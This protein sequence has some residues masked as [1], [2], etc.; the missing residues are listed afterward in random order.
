MKLSAEDD[1]A[2]QT[3]AASK[4]SLVKFRRGNH[5]DFSFGLGSNMAHL[6]RVQPCPFPFHS[7]FTCW[8]DGGA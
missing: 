2:K 7:L 4:A 3:L 6:E 5:A 1:I 8:Y